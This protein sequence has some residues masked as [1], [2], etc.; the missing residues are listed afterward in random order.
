M[1]TWQSGGCELLDGFVIEG[2]PVDQPPTGRDWPGVAG[3]AKWSA[4]NGGVAIR[5]VQDAGQPEGVP[6][7]CPADLRYEEVAAGEAIS[8]DAVWPA[9]L[10]DGRPAPLGQYRLVY[11]FPYIG[12][13]PADELGPSTPAP[14]SI[15]VTIE[16]AVEG[17]AFVGIPSTLA[18]DAALGDPRSAAWVEDLLLPQLNGAEVKFED[19]RWQFTI[20]VTGDRETIVLIDATTGRVID[21]RLAALPA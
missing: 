5:G 1:I 18:I 13:F 7:I 9:R 10:S 12:R 3:L 2:P 21:V 20:M 19:G 16:L 11:A 17:E 15:D 14:R 4:T 6:F 8:L